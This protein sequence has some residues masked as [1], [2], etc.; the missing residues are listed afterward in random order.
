[1]IAIVL[2]LVI[3]GVALEL[4]KSKLPIDSTIRVVIQLV[5]VIAVVLW[6]LAIFGIRDMP[7]PRFP[8]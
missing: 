2:I 3:I 8:R 6:L 4:L 7:V 5:V 1:M